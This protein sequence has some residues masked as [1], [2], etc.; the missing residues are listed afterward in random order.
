MLAAGGLA[1]P[2]HARCLAGAAVRGRY[3]VIEVRYERLFLGRARLI[4]HDLIPS[5]DIPRNSVDERRAARRAED[6]TARRNC[7]SDS[8][9]DLYAIIGRI[10]YLCKKKTSIDYRKSDA[11][12]WQMDSARGAIVSRV[13]ELGLSLSE[14]SIKVGKNHAYFQQFIKRDAKPVAGKCARSGGGNSGN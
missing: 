9:A 7:N 6:G 12:R 3:R 14:L 8:V 1:P 5:R 10:L 2:A 13:A 11:G 4:R